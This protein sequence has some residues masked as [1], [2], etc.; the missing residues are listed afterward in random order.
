MSQTHTVFEGICHPEPTVV[1]VTITIISRA[2]LVPKAA[3]SGQIP[4]IHLR[5]LKFLLGG[6]EDQA[7]LQLDRLP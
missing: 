2:C 1:L 4:C 7:A 6:L 3:T 5:N